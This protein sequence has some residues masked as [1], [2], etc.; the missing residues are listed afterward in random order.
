MLEEKVFG[1]LTSDSPPL[2][3]YPD[4]G[5]AHVILPFL[6]YTFVAGHQDMHLQGRSGIGMT[7]VS[8]SAYASTRSSATAL[9]ERARD[10]L[11][12]S[13]DFTVNS[14]DDPGAERYEPETK[15]YRATLDFTLRYET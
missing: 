13:S 14:I 12:A 9:V 7:I 11:L 6:V 8:I 3:A 10:L 2:R 5:P 4:V 1:A 15:R